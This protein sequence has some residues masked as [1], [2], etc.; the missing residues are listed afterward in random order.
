M[1]KDCFIDNTKQFMTQTIVRVSL[2]QYVLN[3]HPKYQEI[4][5]RRISYHASYWRDLL[6]QTYMP[7]PHI[8]RFN[9]WGQNN[10]VL[11]RLLKERK[12]EEFLYCLQATL[13]NINFNDIT[14]FEYFV[15]V[16]KTVPND[17][18][19]CRDV[20]TGKDLTREDLI[21]EYKQNEENKDN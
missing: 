19:M 13:G 11:V 1:I 6:Q 10:P 4:N 3:R 18:V 5:E 17:F 8:A 2:D 14:V 9:C 20:A 21:K 15:N 7:N 16:L 12:W